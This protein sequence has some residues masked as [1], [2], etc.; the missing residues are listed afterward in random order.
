[1]AAKYKAKTTT[2]KTKKMS[3]REFKA[4]LSGV[5]EMQPEGWFPDVEQWKKI[6]DK[7]S[8]LDETNVEDIPRKGMPAQAPVRDVVGSRPPQVSQ[9]PHRPNV[10]EGLNPPIISPV[11]MPAI[12]PGPSALSD[13]KTPNLDTSKEPYKSPFV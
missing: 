2:S 7:I 1:M 6:R 13:G 10:G 4:W 8:T 3:V 5:E 12:P 9:F 11:H